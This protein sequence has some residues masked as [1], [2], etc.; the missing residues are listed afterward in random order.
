[1]FS[2]NKKEEQELEEVV[3]TDLP[4]K[5]SEK[6]SDN[7][8]DLDSE[9]LVVDFDE[10]TRKQKNQIKRIKRMIRSSHGH[11]FFYYKKA[12]KWKYVY[13]IGA[14]SSILLAG[15]TTIVN[16]FYDTCGSN[17]SGKNV[18]T[19]LSALITVFL[20]IISLLNASERRNDY[21]EAGD[22][23]TQLAANLYREV[24]FSNEPIKDLDLE[25][26]IYRYQTSI[27]NYIERFSQPPPNAIQNIIKSEKFGTLIKFKQ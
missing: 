3:V 16:V 23:Y 15:G 7:D 8:D 24:F 9:K 26:I 25:G 17:S 6:S 22:K 13:W 10:L 21:D 2:G 20:T 19:L 12:Y 1:M 14:V 18:N 4:L 5:S 11:S 27:D